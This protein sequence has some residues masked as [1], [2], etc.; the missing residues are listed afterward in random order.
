MGKK[1]LLV[2]DDAH[3][4]ETAQDI[5][6]AAGYEVKSAETGACALQELG[7]ASV[8]LMIVDYNLTD[9][10]GVELALKAKA[11]RPEVVI[12]LMTGEEDVDLGAA[13][14]FTYAVL[15]KPVNPADLLKLIKQ[16]TI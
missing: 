7:R 6:E 9:T 16:A 11:L 3:I 5:L 2:D 8:H 15:T 1:I 4:L 12:V 14:S 10:T 13:K